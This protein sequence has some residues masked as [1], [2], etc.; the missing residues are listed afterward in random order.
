MNPK[1][2]VAVQAED[3]GR[4]LEEVTNK[5]E[6]LTKAHEDFMEEC[7]K[8]IPESYDGDESM[9]SILIRYLKDVESLSGIIARLT[10]SYRLCRY[11]LTTTTIPRLASE[12]GTV[13]QPSMWTGPSS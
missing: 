1:R 11:S 13:L 2:A 10:S 6:E 7:G 12:T 4:E 3:L 8:Y 9:E 5:L